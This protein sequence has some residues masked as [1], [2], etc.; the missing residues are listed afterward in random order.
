MKTT[1]LSSGHITLPAQTRR[2]LGITAGTYLQ[3]E[4]DISTQ[5]IIL[6]PITRGR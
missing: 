5:R 4:A 2:E 1:R 3:I 6:T